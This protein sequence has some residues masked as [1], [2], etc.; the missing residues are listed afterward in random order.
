MAKTL[1]V[2][3]RRRNSLDKSTSGNDASIRAVPTCAFLA[4]DRPPGGWC[5]QRPS[6]GVM[7]EGS[8]G[9]MISTDSHTVTKGKRKRLTCVSGRASSADT[10]PVTIRSMSRFW[11]PPAAAKKKQTD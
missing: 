2:A 10:R 1:L 4:C 9:K 5:V 6:G 8:D 11:P 3:Q 7:A